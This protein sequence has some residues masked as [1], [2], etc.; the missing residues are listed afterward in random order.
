MPPPHHL[1]APL[2]APFLAAASP[3]LAWHD[4]IEGGLQSGGGVPLDAIIPIIVAVIVGG[5]ALAVWGRKPR[6]KPHRRRRGRR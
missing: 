3:A 6:G 1:W 2:A 4:T 5:V